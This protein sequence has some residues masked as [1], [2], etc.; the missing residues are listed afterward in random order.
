MC[1]HALCTPQ[2]P[3]VLP[4][5]TSVSGIPVIPTTRH[6]SLHHPYPTAGTRPILG[7]LCTAIS[8]TLK[9]LPSSVL[10][11]VL[12]S[13]LFAQ[14][15]SH[16]CCRHVKLCQTAGQKWSG[17]ALLEHA[18]GRQVFS[19]R[20]SEMPEVVVAIIRHERF[21][22]QPDYPFHLPSTLH[23]PQDSHA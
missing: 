18:S 19:R 1:I 7:V 5:Q 4:S 2:G 15:I 16:S 17:S 11:P 6:V 10:L 23:P 12:I 20:Q 3:C 13:L 8:S 22:V 21:Q 9:H 14:A